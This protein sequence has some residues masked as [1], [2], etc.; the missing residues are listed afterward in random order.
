M[1][2]LSFDVGIKNLAINLLDVNNGKLNIEEWNLIDLSNT[3][4]NYCEII[5]KQKKNKKNKN[6]NKN[7]N[8]NNNNN[9]ESLCGFTASYKD[10][11]NKHYCKRH[12]KASS[13]FIPNTELNI[14]Q[15][16]RNNINKLKEIIEM[17]NIIIDD[18][19][20]KTK[21]LKKDDYIKL[22]EDFKNDK[23]LSSI[24]EKTADSNLITLAINMTDKL[25]KFMKNHKNIDIV[26]IENQIG[27]IAVKMKSIQG[28]LTQFFV[29]NNIHNIVYVSSI[30]KLKY[31]SENKKL[32][33]KERKEKS[34][35]VTGE[36]LEKLNIENSWH[37]FFNNNKKKDDLA[38]AFLQAIWYIKHNNLK[39]I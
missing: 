31:F 38:D 29:M 12:A 24:S 14:N 10:K 27:K 39:E 30:N 26:L 8:N 23:I 15:L 11:N 22:I 1:K 36:I 6:K 2:I 21:K 9:D 37:L 16:K 19:I 34:I 13:F 20:Y 28:M 4:K 25:G 18:N 35:K 3:T 32:N 33:Y 5:K 7:N 17:Y